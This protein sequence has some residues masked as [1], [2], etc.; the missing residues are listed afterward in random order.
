MK[1]EI[2]CYMCNGVFVIDTK[3]IKYSKQF[4]STRRPKGHVDY[5]PKKSKKGMPWGIVCP[6][7]HHHLLRKALK[8]EK[9]K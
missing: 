1:K 4:L 5:P 6:Y 8:R 2:E 3:Y 9:V 7:C